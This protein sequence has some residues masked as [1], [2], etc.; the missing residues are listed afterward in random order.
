MNV[1][2]IGAKEYAIFILVLFLSS[3]VCRIIYVKIMN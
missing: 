1:I 2:E 3:I